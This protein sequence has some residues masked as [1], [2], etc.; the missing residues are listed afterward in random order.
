MK[1]T[2][3]NIAE[4]YLQM[5]CLDEFFISTRIVHGVNT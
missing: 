2:Q 5:S 1:N 3:I 4:G